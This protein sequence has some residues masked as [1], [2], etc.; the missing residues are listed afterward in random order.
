MAEHLERMVEAVGE[1]PAPVRRLVAAF[2]EAAT[3]CAEGELSDN[4]AQ[5]LTEFENAREA[6]AHDLD[7]FESEA[8]DIRDAWDSSARDNGGLT[9]FTAR[10]QPLAEAGRDLIRQADHLH[11]LLSRVAEGRRN[12]RSSPLKAVGEA[13][14]EALERLGAP[15][16]FWRQAHWLQDRFPDAVLRDVEGLVKLV[17]HDEL[18]AND[19]SLTPGR[20][21]GV[22]P[23]EEDEDFDFEQTMRD[24][25]VELDELNAE[26]VRLA[27][28]IKR[29]FQALRL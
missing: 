27:A 8:G 12:G 21:V 29:N 26:S 3:T 13:R 6:F 20:Y 25:H 17:G 5:S 2:A 9:A 23:E 14:S 19:W 16:Y 1:A 15:R 4:I 24:I 28:T 11:R 18:A 7:A 22:A 10:A